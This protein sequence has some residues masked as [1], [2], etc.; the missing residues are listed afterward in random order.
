MNK[1]Y[2]ISKNLFHNLNY[3]KTKTSSKICAVV[4]GDAYGHGMRVIANLLKDRVDFFAVANLSEA[5]NFRSFDSSSNLLI[6][7]HCDNYEIA[8]KKNISVTISSFEELKNCEDVAINLDQVCHIHLKIDSGMNRIGIWKKREFK[9]CI[10]LLKTSNYLFF[11]G[12]F[13][14][15]CS[16]R[17]DEDYFKRQKLFFDKM[18]SLIP[19][20]VSPII[21]VGGSKILDFNLNYPMM[22]VGIFLYGYNHSNLK[23]VMFIN[24]EVINVK[25]IKKGE[26]VGYNSAFIADKPMDIATLSIGYFDGLN[27]DFKGRVINNSV[28]FDENMN[29][30]KNTHFLSVC[31]DMSMIENYGQHFKLGDEVT[32]FNDAEIWQEAVGVNTHAILIEFSKMRGKTVVL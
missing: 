26:Q 19:K 18:L 14:H 6:L 32:I 9:K 7:G 2:I 1:K 30:L 8:I 29:N 16:L 17:S 5:V 27:Y 23:K 11:E 31:M 3:I 22:R 20:R 4:K 15:F 12:V 24:S 10:K 28:P 21:H 25:Q 13:T